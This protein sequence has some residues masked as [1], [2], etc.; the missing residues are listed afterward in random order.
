MSTNKVKIETGEIPEATA[1]LAWLDDDEAPCQMV[2]YGNR[3]HYNSCDSEVGYL[4]LDKGLVRGWV[5]MEALRMEA[6]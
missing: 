1:V 4:K 6:A 3:L 2:R 5:A